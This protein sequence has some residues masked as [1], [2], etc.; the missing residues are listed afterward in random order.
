MKQK[1][2]YFGGLHHFF[3]RPATDSMRPTH[4]MED[5]LLSLKYT[6]LNTT[7]IETFSSQKSV[8]WCLW[9]LSYKE[10]A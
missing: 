3:L 2:P 8:G 6:D 9:W 5:N 1:L 4:I 10:Y 7:H